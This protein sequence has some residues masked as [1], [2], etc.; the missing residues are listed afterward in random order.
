MQCVCNL[1]KKGYAVHNNCFT[2]FLNMDCSV[3]N[4]DALKKSIEKV[5]T[6]K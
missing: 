5:Q 3:Y 6:V 1:R 2:N 4:N